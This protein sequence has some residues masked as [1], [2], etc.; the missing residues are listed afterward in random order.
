M[1]HGN[2]VLLS[3]DLSFCLLRP[4]YGINAA[5][6][7][8]R[9]E[10]QSVPSCM[11]SSQKGRHINW[12]SDRVS[13]A[14]VLLYGLARVADSG[15]VTVARSK[16]ELARYTYTSA[17]SFIQGRLELCKVTDTRAFLGSHQLAIFQ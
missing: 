1:Q 17:S 15:A 2:S 8:Y 5:S 7:A 10:Q 11:A 4:V 12:L 9:D 3:T 14:E 16:K 6:S 13:T